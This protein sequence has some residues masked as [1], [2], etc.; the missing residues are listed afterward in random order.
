M[1]YEG[2]HCNL[3]LFLYLTNFLKFRRMLSAHVAPGPKVRYKY[4]Y[5][6]PPP[7]PTPPTPHHTV[8]PHFLLLCDGGG[9]KTIK[10][11]GLFSEYTRRYTDRKSHEFSQNGF[12]IAFIRYSVQR[13][14]NI[15]TSKMH[16]LSSMCST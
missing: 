3:F 2:L 7:H 13:C 10:N 4:M 14:Q 5:S 1:V 15:C 16:L 8:Y 12:S 11:G 6:P 9:S